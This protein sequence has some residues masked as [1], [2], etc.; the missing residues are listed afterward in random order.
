MK[1]QNKK[2]PH[3]FC[4][5]C[6]KPSHILP[7]KLTLLLSFYC[8]VWLGKDHLQKID[9]LQ[10]KSNDILRPKYFLDFI[11]IIFTAIFKFYFAFKAINKKK[12]QFPRQ[13]NG[14]KYV[15][16]FSSLPRPPRIFSD[17]PRFFKLGGRKQIPNKN[18]NAIR[19][20]RIWSTWGMK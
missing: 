11:N 17:L 4:L 3:L 13:N 10:W 12:S 18:T 7:I 5:L 6:S 19:Q 8:W 9:K 2:N 20:T 15:P 1:F 14:R 16:P